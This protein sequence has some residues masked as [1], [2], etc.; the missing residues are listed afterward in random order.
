MLSINFGG[1]V[2][3]LNLRPAKAPQLNMNIA[4]A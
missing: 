2:P 3:K 4:A 1:L